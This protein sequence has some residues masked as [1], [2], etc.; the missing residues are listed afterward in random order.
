MGQAVQI[1]GALLIL[2]GFALLQFRVIPQQS[3]RYQL[4]N[5]LGSLLLAA[6]AY[7]GEQWGFFVL[8][9][10]WAMISAWWTAQLVRE[11]RARA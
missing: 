1:P 5:L 6:D 8:E 2:A 11:R 10:A 4:P 7:V 3:F 9:S